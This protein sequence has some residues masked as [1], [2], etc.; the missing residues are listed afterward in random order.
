[1]DEV[2]NTAA[3][4]WSQL[5]QQAHVKPTKRRKKPSPSKN[6]GGGRKSNPGTRRHMDDIRPME[7]SLRA[8]H[9]VN[10]HV[11]GPGVVRVNTELGRQLQEQDGRAAN[12]DQ[13]FEAARGGI[14]QDNLVIGRRQGG[15]VTKVLAAGALDTPGQPM[16]E[17][18]SVNGATGGAQDFRV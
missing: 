8:Q 16:P 9:C 12:E 1:M 3:L 11:Y 17:F 5:I 4:T 7:V 14:S 6:R 13:R 2:S 18:S 15:Y 10:G